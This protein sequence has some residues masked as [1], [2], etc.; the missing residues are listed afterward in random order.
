MS[1][2]FLQEIKAQVPNGK[3]TETL[4]RVLYIGKSAAYRRTSG[5]APL[6]LEEI[7]LL[8]RHF[9]ISIDQFVFAD[10]DKA[11]F[12][13]PYMQYPVR[14]ISEFMDGIASRVEQAAQLKDVKIDFISREIPIFH[15][16]NFPELT[17]FKAYIWA[18]TIWKLPEF[19]EQRFSLKRIKG[20]KRF[21][22][23]I[24]KHYHT[25]AGSEVWGTDGLAVP[26][27]QIEYYLEQDMFEEPEEALLL[28][29][30]LRA[31]MQHVATMTKQGKKFPL[32]TSPTSDAPD[33]QIYHNQLAHSN[34]FIL[35]TSPQ[36]KV[37]FVTMDNLHPATFTDPQFHQFMNDWK[38]RLTE[39]SMLIS[40][41]SSGTHTKFFNQAEKQISK[42][43]RRI[44]RILE[45][46]AD[47]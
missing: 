4:M 22:K 19:Q 44:N 26:L 24:L 17:A 2:K 29:E 15:Y 35:V 34:S 21:Q 6:S 12:T 3:L 42:F 30:Q 10:T 23:R 28:C 8:A 11:I 14:S 43:E 5:E 46:R 37:S 45:G 47:N 13:F 9:N 25:I 39:Q 20:I 41:S 40:G 27:S 18:R 31:L 33:F 38:T 7:S 36:V 32:G 1:E 16:F